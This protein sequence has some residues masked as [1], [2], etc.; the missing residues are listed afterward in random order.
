MKAAPEI[1]SNTALKYEHHKIITFMIS[2]KTITLPT[3]LYVPYY[4]TDE[5]L[6][7]YG[8]K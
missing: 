5:I 7:M 4:Y 3:C 2:Y 1:I 6:N 8:L